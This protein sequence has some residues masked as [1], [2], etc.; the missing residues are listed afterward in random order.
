MMVVARIVGVVAM[1]IVAM[2]AVA[3]TTSPIQIAA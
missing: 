1:M 3:A 2:I